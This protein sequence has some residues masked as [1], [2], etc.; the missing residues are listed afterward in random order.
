MSASLTQDCYCQL[1]RLRIKAQRRLMTIFSSFIF[2]FICLI[3]AELGIMVWQR[4]NQTVMQ[5]LMA[6]DWFV[7]PKEMAQFDR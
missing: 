6:T 1:L 4:Q 7:V 2:I 3:G 5:I